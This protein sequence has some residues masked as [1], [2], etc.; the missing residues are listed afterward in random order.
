M[1]AAARVINHSINL[2][3]LQTQVLFLFYIDVFK[4]GSLFHLCVGLRPHECEICGKNFF[5]RYNL[6]QHIASIH[7][8]MHNLTTFSPS[9]WDEY[10]TFNFFS[11]DRLNSQN[12]TNK[13]HTTKLEGLLCRIFMLIISWLPMKRLNCRWGRTSSWSQSWFVDLRCLDKTWT[14]LDT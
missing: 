11:G 1:L 10:L 6:I 2:F 8:G 3:Y 4:I 13:I 7:N 14:W 5:Q 12:C 9:Y